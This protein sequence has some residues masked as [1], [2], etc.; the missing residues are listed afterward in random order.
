VEVPHTNLHT[1]T[2]MQ[3]HISNSSCFAL[4]AAVQLLQASAALHAEMLTTRLTHNSDKLLAAYLSEE[5]RM[6]LVK[7]DAVVVLATSI[8]AASWMLAVLANTTVASADVTTL[9]AVLPEPCK[10]NIPATQLIGYC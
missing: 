6:V 4:P 5:T 2:I 10:R 9:L 1:S 7:Q 3:Q 8:S